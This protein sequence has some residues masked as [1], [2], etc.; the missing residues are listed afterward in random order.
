MIAIRMMRGVSAPTG[1]RTD[2]YS[3]PMCAFTNAM[4]ESHRRIVGT[5]A[6]EPCFVGVRLRVVENCPKRRDPPEPRRVKYERG[7]GTREG[8]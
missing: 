5:I 1:L 3:S 6:L 4:S 2:M 7:R 8:G